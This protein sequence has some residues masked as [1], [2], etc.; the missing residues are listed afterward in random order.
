MVEEK[1]GERR[2][3]RLDLAANDSDEVLYVGLRGLKREC[4]QFFVPPL[5]R[6]G[7]APR[8]SMDDYPPARLEPSPRARCQLSGN[9]LPGKRVRMPDPN[10]QPDPGATTGAA[11]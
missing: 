7:I 9:I 3:A 1:L 10:V 5:T 11:A 4:N 8:D 6:E 2:S